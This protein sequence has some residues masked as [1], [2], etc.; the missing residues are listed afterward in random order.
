[1]IIV[2]K[3][4]TTETGEVESIQMV[5]EKSRKLTLPRQPRQFGSY[6][7]DTL[8]FAQSMDLT[9]DIKDP[10][11]VLPGFN[12]SLTFKN[13]QN[14]NSKEVSDHQVVVGFGNR[15]SPLF[16]YRG[17]F[18]HEDKRFGI[19]L[20]HQSIR[21]GPVR[22]DKSGLSENQIS[23]YGTIKSNYLEIGVDATYDRNSFFY[24]GLSDSILNSDNS[25]FLTDRIFTNRLTS[26]LYLRS[27]NRA[28]KLF[29]DIKPYYQYVG[30]NE[31]DNSAFNTENGMGIN[32]NLKFP[33]RSGFLTSLKLG[34]QFQQYDNED[35]S[36]VFVNPGT[37]YSF[38]KLHLNLGMNLTML[39]ENSEISFYVFPDVHLSYSVIPDFSVYADFA[40]GVMQN[41]LY[42]LSM[43]NP[44]LQDS[45]DLRSSIENLEFRSGVIATPVRGMTLRTGLRYSNIENMALYLN[46]ISDSSRFRMVYDGGTSQQLFYEFS[47]D[48]RLNQAIV[49]FMKFETG[50]FYMDSVQTAYHLPRTTFSFDSEYRLGKGIRVL[51]GSKMLTGIRTLSTA[52]V[53]EQLDPVFQS[54]LKL[55]YQPRHQFSVFTEFNNLV[56]QRNERYL[57]YPGMPVTGRIGINLSF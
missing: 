31:R 37:I 33:E 6:R 27:V 46:S 41:T 35:R 56:N 45:L 55:I 47:L 34:G 25:S 15:I 26:N 16:D 57:N 7:F 3:A 53:V 49:I 36:W 23:G 42:D 30:Q 2:V 43:Q 29:F 20:S 21:N 14:T 12:P 5:V 9:Y 28:D 48:Y 32:T 17:R 38:K 19:G 51:L 11:Y 44:F 24:Y 22:D 52:G 1:V 13:Y 10:E 39:N 54:R 50:R 4:Q 8:Q 40:G 18:G